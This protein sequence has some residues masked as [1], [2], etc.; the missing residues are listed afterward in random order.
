MKALLLVNGAEVG[1]VVAAATTDLV[2]VEHVSL[3]AAKLANKDELGS[4]GGTE[5]S[6]K[7]GSG[8]SGSINRGLHRWH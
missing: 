6:D 1:D 2:K 5:V 8:L 4:F 3:V 7:S